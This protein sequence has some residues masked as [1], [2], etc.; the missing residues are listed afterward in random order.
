MNKETG[1]L[2]SI[3]FLANQAG[4]VVAHGGVSVVNLVLVRHSHSPKPHHEHDPHRLT[5]SRNSLLHLLY[6][7]QVHKTPINYVYQPP[8]LVN[9]LLVSSH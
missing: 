2:E 6:A 9:I 4:V 7:F 5:P 1:L 8:N 3:G